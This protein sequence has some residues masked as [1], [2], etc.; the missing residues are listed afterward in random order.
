MEINRPDIVAQVAAAFDAYERALVDND[1]AAM[2]ALFWDTPETVRYGIAEV[3]RGGETIRAWR[4]TCEPVPRSRRLHR[5][6]VTT[7]GVD[8]AT[9]S[10][11]FTS[12]ATPLLG[13]QMQTWARLGDG[14]KIVAA[15]VSLIQPPQ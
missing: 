3:Q 1:V 10:T 8:Y 7:F 9:V 5:T 11:E 13:R 4:E 14:W 15:H 2:N 6:V 12:D